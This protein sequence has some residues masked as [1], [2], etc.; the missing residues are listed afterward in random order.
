MRV[1]V[2][3]H[4]GYI[5]SILTGMLADR[6]HDV[7]GLDTGYFSDCKLFDPDDRVI[8]AINLDVR[9]V[10]EGDLDGIDGI[11]RVRRPEN[12]K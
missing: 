9:E 3:G 7:V 4:L 10:D 5:G 1:M 2:T 12:V 8:Q 6:G 11:V